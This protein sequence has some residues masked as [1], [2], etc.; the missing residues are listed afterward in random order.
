MWRS[1]A[2]ELEPVES[3]ETA[4]TAIRI[5]N[6]RSWKKALRAVRDTDGFVMDVTDEEIAEAKAMIGRDGIGCE[7]A[8]ATT[9]AALRKLTEQ[10]KI[11]RDAVVVAILTGH[12]LK[13]TDYILKSHLREPALARSVL[14]MNVI[15]MN[16][17]EKAA[18]QPATADNFEIRVPASIANL[19]PGFDTLAVAVQ[20][21]LSLSV[22]KMPGRGHLEF[23]FVDHELSGENHIERA[24]QIARGREFLQ[25]AFLIGGGAQRHSH[26]GWTRQQRGGDRRG[27]ASV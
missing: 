17:I 23:R 24:Y 4:A 10:G 11:D 14:R 21:Y 20:L 16:P 27:T 8:S 6:P 15:G 12:A 22:R 25:A 19:G 2:A 13:D 1:G 7:P 3:P 9:L 26:A 18:T 5:G